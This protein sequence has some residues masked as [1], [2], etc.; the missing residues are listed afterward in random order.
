MTKPD[1]YARLRRSISIW[2]RMSPHEEAML[3]A[4]VQARDAPR[5]QILRSLVRRAYAELKSEELMSARRD[6]VQEAAR[7]ALNNRIE[8]LKDEMFGAQLHLARARSKKAAG[9]GAGVRTGVGVASAERPG[10]SEAS[11]KEAKGVHERLAAYRER[12]RKKKRSDA[13]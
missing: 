12:S 9:V 11:A 2:F 5:A 6:V 10:S 13:R 4:L 3:A 7:H 1:P 8:A